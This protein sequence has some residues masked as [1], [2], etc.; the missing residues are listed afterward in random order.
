MAGSPEKF[1]Q[2]LTTGIQ[3]IRIR[4]GKSIRII[5]D[6]LGYLLGREGGSAIEHWRKGRLPPLLSDVEQLARAI[7]Q[8]GSLDQAWLAAFLIS[9]GHPAPASVVE[10]FLPA[11]PDS[12]PT[13]YPPAEASLPT[14][15]PSR[16]NLPTPPLPIIGRRAELTTALALLRR[17]DS[18]LVTLSG[19]GGSGKTRLALEIAWALVPHFADGVYFVDLAPVTDPDLVV[20]TIVHTLG[21]KETPGHA[22]DELLRDFLR[23]KRLLLVLDN[24]E[25]VVAA[26]PRLA[27][28]RS[29][30]PALILL[31]TSR[32]L[33][34]LRGERELPVPPLQLPEQVETLATVA[35]AEAVQLFV[36]RVRDL[37][38]SFVLTADNAATVAAICTQLG[39]LPLALELAA[40]RS[41]VL[42]PEALLERLAAPLSLLTRGARDLPARQQTLRATIAWSVDLLTP[43]EQILFRRLGVFRGSFALE[44]VAAVCDAAGDLAI[45]VLDGLTTLVD[46]HLIRLAPSGHA[47]ETRFTLLETI[48]SYAQEQLA[49]GDELEPLRQQHAAYYFALAEEANAKLEGPEQ[50]NWLARLETDLD[51]LRAALA[52]SQ[53]ETS[54]VELG[55]RLADKLFYFWDRRGYVSEGRTWLTTLLAHPGAATPTVARAKALRAGGLLAGHQSDFTEAHL[56]L[57]E[58][59]T[60]CRTLNDEYNLAWSLLALAENLYHRPNST[61]IVLEESLALFRELGHQYGITYVLGDLGNL[62]FQRHDY[63][64]ATALYEEGLALSYSAE[65]KLGVAGS[66]GALGGLAMAQ[67][68]YERAE[69][70]YEESLALMR[71]L[72]V[73]GSRLGSLLYSRGELAH[74]QGNHLRASAL[75]EE[76]LGYFHEAGDQWSRA[77]ALCY[78]ADLALEDGDVARTQEL[79]TESLQIYRVL[80]DPA[81]PEITEVYRDVPRCIAVAAKLAAAKQDPVRAARLFAA[82]EALYR[83]Q[84]AIQMRTLLPDWQAYERAKAN[85]QEELDP[86]AFAVAWAAGAQSIRQHEQKP[87]QM[88]LSTLTALEVALPGHSLE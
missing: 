70:L 71:E 49:A 83:A 75:Y 55:L 30:T 59:V 45:D 79:L 17:D 78:V 27:E 12:A 5:Q 4:E 23:D 73:K 50:E 72:G 76:S 33:L 82:A 36:A 53:E 19:P 68:D 38:P 86:A 11:T 16:H 81:A 41:N 69:T 61:K 74:A 32:T 60:L 13:A 37:Q 62:A 6:E 65:D 26:A 77:R 10:E 34:R 20:P 39:G 44:G 58:S 47:G 7:V 40:A 9:A 48:R 46:H 8:R 64:Q 18:W 57:E 88:L 51:N 54:R 25:Q 87:E 35:Q 1:A 66:L 22:F 3:Q 84:G 24:F 29:Q 2:L 52:W 14:S 15:P 56:F 67:G 21:V 28:L 85:V 43:A 63:A 31:V 80:M 42:S